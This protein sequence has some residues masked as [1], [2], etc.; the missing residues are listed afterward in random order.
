MRCPVWSNVPSCNVPDHIRRARKTELRQRND[1]T[2]AE[3]SRCRFS[4]QPIMLGS[5]SAIERRERTI[6][7][8]QHRSPGSLRKFRRHRLQ[9]RCKARN[10]SD[11][12]TGA[13]GLFDHCFI[14]LQHRQWCQVASHCFDPRTKSGAGE[15]HAVRACSRRI[16]PKL[17]KPLG[18][19]R[20]QRTISGE[21]R[22]KTIVEQI[23]YRHFR[24]EPLKR[25]VNWRRRMFECMD[26]CK[27]H[28]RVFRSQRA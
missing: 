19:P 7:H 17:K 9:C 23:H 20:C 8:T 28:K 18:H 25:C 27:S 24:P 1:V 26:E 13:N 12:A 5:I 15:K 3:V 22:R 16:S 21:V 6:H 2:A 10:Q 14:R 11:P 4:N